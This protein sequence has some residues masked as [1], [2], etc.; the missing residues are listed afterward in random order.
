M[1]EV[2]IRELRNEGGSV[3][4]RV[5]EGELVTITKAGHPIAELRPLGRPT[6]TAAQLLR[7]WKNVPTID[8]GA[9]RRDLDELLDAAL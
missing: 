6:M 8:A 2:S 7:R 4:E 9:L 5:L 1:G 3:L